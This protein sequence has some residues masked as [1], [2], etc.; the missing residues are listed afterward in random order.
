M[1]Q[2][3]GSEIKTLPDGRMDA[4]N[5]AKYIGVKEKT[6]AMWRCLGTVP[7][8][9]KRGRIFYFKDDLDEWIMKDGKRTSTAKG[10]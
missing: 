7:T 3:I 10:A 6:L 2:E 9:I 4:V 8:Y 5:A 1:N